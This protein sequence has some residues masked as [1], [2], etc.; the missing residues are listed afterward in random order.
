MGDPVSRD[1]CMLIRPLFFHF[2]K[3]IARM[4]DVLEINLLIEIAISLSN[5]YG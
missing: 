3:A 4:G 5:A 2:T 1:L